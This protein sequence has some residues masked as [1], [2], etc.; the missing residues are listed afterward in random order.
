MGE[1]PGMIARYDDIADW[2]VDVVQRDPAG[3]YVLARET[4]RRELAQPGGRC[5]DLSCGSAHNSAALAE[6]GWSVVGLDL[7]ER[8]LRHAAGSGVQLVQGDAHHLPLARQSVDAAVMTFVHTD[9]HDFGLALREVARVLRPGAALVAVELHPCFVGPFVQVDECGQRRLDL[10]D[11]LAGGW[12]EDSANFG[13]GIRRRV[14]VNQLMLADFL[15]CFLGAGLRLVKLQEPP[16]PV[17]VL[18]VVAQR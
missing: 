3:L 9:L 2:Y 17:P 8:M 1:N 15:N 13:D 18:T 5:L 4:F 16:S 14:G 11:Y 10:D 7:S 12:I 6:L